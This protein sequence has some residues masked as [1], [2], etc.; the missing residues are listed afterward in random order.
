MENLEKSN[1]ILPKTEKTIR[2]MI[3]KTTKAFDFIRILC[4]ALYLVFL[5]L[6][7]FFF[8][9]ILWLDIVFIVFFLFQF[10]F[11]I[12]DYKNKF[13][14]KKIMHILFSIK[15]VPSLLMIIL[16]CFDIFSDLNRLMPWQVVMTIFMGMGWLILFIGDLFIYFAA[17]FADKFLESFKKDIEARGVLS[18][19]G[20]ELKEVACDKAKCVFDA[21]NMGEVAAKTGGL[22]FGGV[23][24]V[25]LL[26]KLFKKMQNRKHK[27]R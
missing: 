22:L 12:L 15:L 23:G 7:V 10:I 26:D 5:S 6:R 4:G 14:T 1:Y 19:A 20:N 24:G 25:Y 13:N 18:R 8:S 17:P 16:V 3:S 11:L 21:K 2:E 27:E 9:N